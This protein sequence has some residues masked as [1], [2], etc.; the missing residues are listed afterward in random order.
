MSK[1]VKKIYKTHAKK[2]VNKETKK[3]ANYLVIVESPSKC[4]KIES[5]LGPQYQCIASKG[6]IREITGLKDIDIMHS[7]SPKFTIIQEKEDHVKWMRS[8]IQQFPKE[9]VLVATDDDREGEGIAWHIYQV[10]DLP[11]HLD[12]RIVFHEITQSAIQEAI[13][14]PRQ[15]DMQ[16][17]KAQQARQVLDVIVG[18]K[19]SPFLWKH[20]QQGKK[21]TALSAG[22]CQTPALRLIYDNEKLCRESE[23]ELLYKTKGH[24]G[25]RALEFVLEHDFEKEEETEN[26]LGLSTNF[27]HIL[28]IGVEKPMIK[29]SP[30]PFNTSRLLQMASSLLKSSPK[31]TMQTCQELYQHG[32][33]TYMRT[34]NTK[35]SVAFLDTAKNYIQSIYQDPRYLGNLDAIENKDAINPH[36]AIRCTNISLV[37]LSEE[38]S[39]NSPRMISMYALIWRNTVESCMANATY[40]SVCAY[41]QGP[42]KHKYQRILEIP[43]FLGWKKVGYQEK[44]DDSTTLFYLQSQQGKPINYTY[45]ESKIQIRGKKTHYTESG[46]IQELEEMGIGRPSTFSMLVETVQERGYVKCTDIPGVEKECTEF[47]LRKGEILDKQ[48]VKRELGGEKQKL[49]IQPIGTLCI[50]FLIQYFGPLFSYDYTKKMEEQLDTVAK[51]GVGE[52]TICQECDQTIDTLSKNLSSMKRQEIDI[53]ES[54]VFVITRNGPAIR[55][56]SDKK[57]IE[58]QDKTKSTPRY[59]SIKPG[60]DIDMNRL[61]E[62]E[63]SL[64]DLVQEQSINLGEYQGL[65]I[66]IKRGKYGPY[67]EWKDGKKKISI[68][69]LGKSSDQITLQDATDFLDNLDVSPNKKDGQEDSD[70]KL[71]PPTQ[72]S[73]L[74]II[75]TDTSVRQGKFGPY[76]FYKTATMKSPTFIALKGFKGKWETCSPNTLL[77]WV[78]EHTNPPSKIK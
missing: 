16:L 76:L 50:E 9:C 26:F 33:I 71:A 7:Y 78:Q 29:G 31:Q 40:K 6:H 55:C 66:Y 17:V 35:Y 49:R 11:T 23:P 4:A 63:Y 52:D 75:D 64:E 60:L 62:G 72:K 30:K 57:N 74:R 8:M 54:H 69:H 12:N 5:Y 39:S 1:I 48:I 20:I 24:F 2:V 3:T 58:G 51:E 34:E 27:Q 56:K 46:L 59:L 65:P 32:Y 47:I 21:G 15:L 61:K 43:I 13:R 38:V 42:E 67:L 53:D 22:R 28:D 41:I 77:T 10:F 25:D 19:V 45:I 68:K 70:I 44:N 14:Y 37:V 36:E 18:F 73:I